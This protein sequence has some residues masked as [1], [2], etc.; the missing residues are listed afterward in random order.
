MCDF[1]KDC[2][3]GDDEELCNNYISGILTKNTDRTI[4]PVI[5]H[6]D[7][8][9]GFTDDIIQLNQISKELADEKEEIK[10][11]RNEYDSVRYKHSK[12]KGMFTSCPESH[13]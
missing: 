10:N 12:H 1:K 9:G 6:L 2:L 3:E 7:G 13:F 4:P 5:I 11:S 8:Q